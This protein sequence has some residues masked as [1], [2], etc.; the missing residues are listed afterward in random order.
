VAGQVSGLLS[1]VLVL[2][3]LESLGRSDDPVSVVSCWAAAQTLHVGCRWAALS[4]LRPRTLNWRRAQLLCAIWLDARG[5]TLPSPIDLGGG[6]G[7]A[8]GL[9]GAGGSGAE[10]RDRMMDGSGLPWPSPWGGG[11][12]RARLGCSAADFVRA[13]GGADA[14]AVL[15]DAAR[16]EGR[17]WAAA[18]DPAAGPGAAVVALA[19][20][21]EPRDALAGMLAAER[22][23]RGL[24]AAREAV[25]D[26]EALEAALLEA[27][28]EVNDGRPVFVFMPCS[29]DRFPSSA[30]I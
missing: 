19:D 5:G 13:A 23:H 16:A 25:A 12:R 4:A 7:W 1:S 24:A 21:A 10:A 29:S 6:P 26:A 2:A 27:G 18:L 15:L 28:W 8:A 22:L 9:N 11:Q 14:A 20:N 17:R 3:A 30:A